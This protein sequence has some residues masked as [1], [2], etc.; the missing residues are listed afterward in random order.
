[1]PN[2]TAPTCSSCGY[3]FAATV[4]RE[5]PQKLVI[6]EHLHNEDNGAILVCPKCQARTELEEF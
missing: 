4:I 5:R 2:E 1:M 6:Y 3:T